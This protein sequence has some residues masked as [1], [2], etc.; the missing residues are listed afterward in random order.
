MQCLQSLLWNLA[1]ELTLKRNMTA[2]VPVK[3]LLEVSNNMVSGHDS[4]KKGTPLSLAEESYIHK[5]SEKQ[6]RS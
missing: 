3:F 5:E 1:K 4:A 6:L 2:N